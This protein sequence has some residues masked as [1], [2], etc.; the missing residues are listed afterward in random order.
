MSHN[1]GVVGCSATKGRRGWPKGGTGDLGKLRSALEGGILKTGGQ[2]GPRQAA[3]SFG[4]GYM[5][6]RTDR[7]CL[8]GGSMTK[9]TDTNLYLQGVL[10]NPGQNPGCF[11]GC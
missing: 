9:E 6:S 5:K 8:Q 10:L 1:P 2:R 7:G 11:L 3:V 4:G